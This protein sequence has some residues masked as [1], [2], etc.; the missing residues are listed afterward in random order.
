MA[1]PHRVKHAVPA[2]PP[3]PGLGEDVKDGIA[4]GAGGYD[5][6]AAV[7]QLQGEVHGLCLPARHLHRVDV[8]AALQGAD[9]QQHLGALPDAGDG[10]IQVPFVFDAGVGNGAPPV[11]EG[12]G[13]AEEVA[14]HVIGKPEVLQAGEAVGNEDA[15]LRLLADD[16]VHLHGKGL[17]AH[18]GVQGVFD[19]VGPPAGQSLRVHHLR[20]VGKAEVDDPLAGSGHAGHQLSGRKD[21]VPH[22]LNLPGHRVPPAQ[23]I[24]GLIQAVNACTDSFL[25]VHSSTSRKCFVPFLTKSV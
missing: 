16:P 8:G 22:V 15:V 10:L 2:I 21:I 1:G 6:A 7:L 5:P 18:H 23:K 25:L 19:H 13:E 20:M 9:V 24:Q 12:A 11:T 3:L 4:F 14:H 17:K